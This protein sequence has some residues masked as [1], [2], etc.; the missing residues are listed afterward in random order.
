MTGDGFERI[1]KRADRVW[2]NAETWRTGLD[3]IHEYMMPMRRHVGKTGGQPSVDRL[4]DG[5]G[6]KAMFRFAGR[7]QSDLT[8]IDERFFALEPG[9][10]IQDPA[11]KQA[12]ARQLDP[13]AELVDAVNGASSW[14]TTS[15]EM[16]AD[17]FAG[18]G[19]LISNPGPNGQVVRDTAVPSAEIALEV[20]PYGD[21]DGVVWRREHPADDL[22]EMFPRHRWSDALASQMRQEG[23]K[24]IEVTQYTRHLPSGSWRHVA[25]VKGEEA[26]TDDQVMRTTPWITPRFFVVPGFSHGFGVAHLALPFVKT[27]NKTRELALKAA[28]FALLGLWVRRND[29]TFNP[30]TA[31]FRPGAFWTVESTGG[32]LGPTVQRLDVPSNFDVSS[33][34]LEDERE[35]IKQAT[36]DD[37]LP[38]LT[39]SVRS[40]TEIVERMRRLD[41]D[42]AGVDGRLA[43]EIIRPHVMR[44]IDL[45]EQARILPTKLTIDQLLVRISV[46]SP[47]TRSRRAR[48]AQTVV[49]TLQLST[50]LV[51]QELT[52]MIY[53]VEAAAAQIGRELGMP[54]KLIRTDA[55]R[56]ALQ[57]MLA[58]I[59]AQQQ[60][61]A[62]QA[63]QRGAA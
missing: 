8:P 18:Q 6:P 44:R 41:M 57:K 59:L 32:P 2:N 58:A 43:M 17:L 12:L 53:D 61:A 31:R 9:P 21:V 14:H 35:Q 24:A 39:G 15:H 62:Q 47:V 1:K 63:A 26:F 60:M 27:A 3:V 23:E 10:L 11:D 33:I 13:I 4:F 37:T 20:G 34:V 5:T 7:A 36:F 30:D 54:E 28:A 48:M 49:E 16:Y 29:M 38:P 42:W 56:A 51:G 40:P 22:E 50:G 52:A 19:A 55:D 45:L 46:T 25:M